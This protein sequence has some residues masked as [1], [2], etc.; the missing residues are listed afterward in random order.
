[1]G[2]DHLTCPLLSNMRMHTTASWD[3]SKQGIAIDFLHA[4]N[5]N[6]THAADCLSPLPV[7]G[8]S[9]ISSWKHCSPNRIKSGLQC[10][11]NSTAELIR[12]Q[13]SFSPTLSISS[14]GARVI[15]LHKRY[16]PNPVWCNEKKLP[17]CTFTSLLPHLVTHFRGDLCHCIS[18]F[19]ACSSYS[20]MT[21]LMK[22]SY[23]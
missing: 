3:A 15:R 4:A 21:T 9:P 12:Q 2:R 23:P 14:L 20:V 6:I 18:V 1:M 22:N 16:L 5:N 10:L 8:P 7:L 13:S 19:T 11:K 17:L